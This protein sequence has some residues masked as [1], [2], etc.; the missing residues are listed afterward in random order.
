M[1]LRRMIVK[2]VLMGL[3]VKTTGTRLRAAGVAVVWPGRLTC[4]PAI[5]PRTAFAVLD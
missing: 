3:N 2:D 5:P 1:R 4:Y